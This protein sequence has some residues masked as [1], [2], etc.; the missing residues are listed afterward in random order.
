MAS[1]YAQLEHR[2][3]LEWG[4]VGAA[5]TA[6]DS[7]YAVVV[8]VLSFTTT[9]SVAMD[10]GAE[11]LPYGWR[12]DSAAELARTRAATLAVGRLEARDDDQPGV[13]SLSPATLRES[14]R[15]ERLV[16]PSPNGSAISFALAQGG[17]QVV[18]GCL[19]NRSAVAEWLAPRL[20]ADAG[21]SVVLVAAGERWASDDSLRPALEDLLGAGALV[22]AL[23]AAGVGGWSPEA[24]AAVYT[25]EAFQGSLSDVLRACGSGQ[26][27]IGR[28]FGEDVDIA[29]ELDRSP[30]VPVLRGDAFV[31][32]Q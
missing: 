11:V 29:A 32:A 31:R 22:S 30:H 1:P 10:I 2:V 27:L 18:G 15:V 7:T 24:S 14:T 17:A 26:E 3:R 13:V 8:D 25:F 4:P 5:E 6:P 9:L 23:G 12:D 19:R 28:G 20:L 21:A 16:L